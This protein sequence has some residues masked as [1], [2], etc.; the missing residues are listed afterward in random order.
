[1]DDASR[2]VADCVAEDDEKALAAWQ[3]S[4]DLEVIDDV[5]K[6]ALASRV[7]EAYSQGQPWSE[8]YKELLEEL[9]G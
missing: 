8:S 3:E 6:E 4:G 9:R 5:D 2:R 1:L 7:E